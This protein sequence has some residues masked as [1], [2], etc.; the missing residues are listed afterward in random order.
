ML[1]SPMLANVS[2][3]TITTSGKSTVWV[4]LPSITSWHG[5]YVAAVRRCRYS[6]SRK[7]AVLR[8]RMCYIT[9]NNS[10]PNTSNNT[11]DV[12]EQQTQ[13]APAVFFFFFTTER[14]QRWTEVIEIVM[15]TKQVTSR[16]RLDGQIDFAGLK[17]GRWMVSREINGAY[18]NV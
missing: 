8:A 14:L 3:S 18:I 7:D 10:G 17:D 2:G 5:R 12:G 11:D 4:K 16:H 6:G 13:K 1:L 15:I 9:A